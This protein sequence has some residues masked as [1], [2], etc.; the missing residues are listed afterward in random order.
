MSILEAIARVWRGTHA[1]RCGALTILRTHEKEFGVPNANAAPFIITSH[2]EVV[3]V[4]PLTLKYLYSLAR[5]QQAQGIDV[6]VAPVT[7]ERIS[8][9]N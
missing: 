1:W 9:A 8:I 6:R 7:R 2:D 4:G 3:H 5:E